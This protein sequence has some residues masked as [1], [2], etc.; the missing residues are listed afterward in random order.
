MSPISDG[1]YA[2]QKI[3]DVMANVTEE[4]IKLFLGYAK[5]KPDLYASR[6]W[7]IS[8][9]FATWLNGNSPMGLE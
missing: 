3:S 9:T 1:Y 6:T 8:E 7:K 5:I 4:D 2:K